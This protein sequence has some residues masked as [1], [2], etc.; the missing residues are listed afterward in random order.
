MYTRINVPTVTNL[1]NGERMV[2]GLGKRIRSIRTTKGFTLIKLA[3]LAKLSKTSLS[4][5]E[6]EKREPSVSQLLRLAYVL[7]VDANYLCRTSEIDGQRVIDNEEDPLSAKAWLSYLNL[8]YELRG[9][10]NQIITILEHIQ[11][12]INRHTKK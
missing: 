9:Y 7:H 8:S 3:E 10:A 6:C 5:I 2:I 1:I 11:T 4:D 12:S